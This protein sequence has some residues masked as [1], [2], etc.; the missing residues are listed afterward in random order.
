MKQ[1]LLRFTLIELLVVIAIIAI[2]ASMLLPA[3]NQARERAH[4]IRCTGNI[5]QISNAFLFYAGDNDDLM[6]PVVDSDLT[7]WWDVTRIWKKIYNQEWTLQLWEK[8]VFSCPSSLRLSPPVPTGV[9]SHYVMN[10]GLLGTGPMEAKKITV[11]KSPSQTLWVT[12]GVGRHVQSSFEI[13]YG[14]CQISVPHNNE[15]CNMFFIDGHAET[16]Q[17]KHF[18]RDANDI[19]WKGI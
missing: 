7:N 10:S 13:G 5:K 18:V 4:T 2:L 11:F 16:R 19:F 14:N 3:L 12:E 1:N 17:P 9:S 6:P 15:S 8:S